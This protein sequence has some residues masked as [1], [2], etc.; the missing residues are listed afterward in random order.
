MSLATPP[1]PTDF[2]GHVRTVPGNM[3]VKFEVRNFDDRWLSPIYMYFSYNKPE[4]PAVT[5]LSQIRGLNPGIYGAW[6]T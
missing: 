5:N 2:K 3:Q 1:C 4:S 6:R